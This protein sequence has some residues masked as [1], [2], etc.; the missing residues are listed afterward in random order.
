MKKI[1]KFANVF[2]KRGEA[3]QQESESAVC[4]CN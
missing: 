3:E 1:N 2:R 4:M